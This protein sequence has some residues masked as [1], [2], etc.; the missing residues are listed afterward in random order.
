MADP[1]L[2]DLDIISNQTYAEN[3]YPH[4]AWTRLRREAPVHRFERGLKVPFWAI[5]KHEDVLQISRRPRQNRKCR[6]LS[7]G[8]SRRPASTQLKQ[9]SAQYRYVA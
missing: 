6:D 2:D 3:G 5:T 8:L 7:I 1:S 4:E 9:S